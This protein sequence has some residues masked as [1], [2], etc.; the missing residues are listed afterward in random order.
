MR[1]C[2]LDAAAAPLMDHMQW[3]KEFPI[4]M[5]SSFSPWLLFFYFNGTRFFV[6]SLTLSFDLDTFA[7]DHGSSRTLVTCWSC[8]ASRSIRIASR[9]KTGRRCKHLDESIHQNH[10]WQR[11]QRPEERSVARLFR[12]ICKLLFYSVK[13]VFVFD[14]GAPSLKRTMIVKM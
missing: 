3:R 14:G 9:S 4:V 2:Q 7:L 1:L 13:P 6:L 8:S 5:E 12:R 11:R 10:A